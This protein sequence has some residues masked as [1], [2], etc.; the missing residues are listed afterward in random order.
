MLIHIGLF[1]KTEK[2]I[3][4]SFSE[5]GGGVFT[6]VLYSPHYQTLRD[7]YVQYSIVGGVSEIFKKNLPHVLCL[8]GRAG[9]IALLS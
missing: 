5:G 8:K 1:I 4:E 3:N 7:V 6:S 2:K 9:R